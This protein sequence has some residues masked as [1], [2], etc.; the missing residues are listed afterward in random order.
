M[1]GP[2][3]GTVRARAGEEGEYHHSRNLMKNIERGR[4]TR[5]ESRTRRGD[6]LRRR[7]S[8]SL[9]LVG[10]PDDGFAAW[11]SGSS[12]SERN[13][14]AERHTSITTRARRISRP[15]QA[16]HGR[17]KGDLSNKYATLWASIQ[18]SNAVLH[19]G[20][21]LLNSRRNCSRRVYKAI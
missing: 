15:I 2:L 1:G 18:S 20:Y 10:G 13:R 8:R 16:S 17:W 19:Q 21:K 11:D 3:G 6:D 9:R 7:V 14:E 12:N 5:R 4:R